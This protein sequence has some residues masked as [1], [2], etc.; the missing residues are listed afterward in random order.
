MNLK[1]K[2]TAGTLIPKLAWR[3]LMGAGLRTWLNVL[4][5]SL[6]FFAIIAIQGLLEGM[7][8][9]TAQSM[10]DVI[11]GNGQYWSSA[12][13]PYDPLTLEDAH[14]KLDE[15]L[16]RMIQNGEATAILTVQGNMYPSGRIKP[17]LINGIAP[18]QNVLSI[19]TGFLKDDEAD[20]PALIGNRE[21]ESS[22]LKVGDYVTVQWRDVNGTY[23][24][25][26]VRIVQVMQ[27]TVQNIDNGQI[28]IPLERLQELTGMPDEAT[29]VV[30]GKNILNPPEISGWELK[31]L[32]FLLKDLNDLIRS[33]SVGSSLLYLILLF[34]AMLAIFDTQVLSVFRRRK[35]MGTIMALGMT[36]PQVI[37]LFTLEGA[38][39]GVLAA[40]LAAIYGIPLLS[41]LARTGWTLPE[42]TDSYGFA[43]GEKLFP[44]FSAGLVLG[45]T[46]LVLI[47][48]TVVSFL[49]TRKISHLKPTDALRGRMT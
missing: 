46:L 45:T 24:A 2:T 6:S 7:N 20:I 8:R 26:D 19:P 18:D 3:N 42:T 34:L 33:K 47:V 11:Y 28:W 12:Y 21:S 4:V 13:D 30:V 49:P 44:A 43:I 31:N 9:Q 5:L 38:L 16:R 35:E 17:I 1:N 25:R 10:I 22:G 48:T 15:N 37:R 40:V 29:I 41:W 23:D 36:R 27:T 14:Q 39:H 32:D